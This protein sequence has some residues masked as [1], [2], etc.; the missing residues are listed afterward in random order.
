M[1]RFI[2]AM[3]FVFLFTPAA[4][5]ASEPAPKIAVPKVEIFVTEWCPYCRKLETFLKDHHVE[6]TRYNVEKDEKG[7]NLFTELGGQ[8]VPVSRVGKTVIHGYDPEGLMAALEADGKKA[9]A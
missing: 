3:S 9:H 6:Y 2:C 1:K 7:Y 4:F 8:G 5:A